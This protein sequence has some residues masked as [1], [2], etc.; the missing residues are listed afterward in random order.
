MMRAADTVMDS[1]V[2]PEHA[3]NITQ[4]IFE[5]SGRDHQIVHD[6]LL[7][8][9]GDDGDD[10]LHDVNHMYWTDDGKAAGSLFSWTNEAH[11]GPEADIASATAEK[12]AQY[13]GS[14]KDELMN[15]PGMP[16]EMTLGQVNPELVKGYAH[17]LTPYMADIASISGGNPDDN[18]GFLDPANSER[19]N[20]KG[21]FSVLGTQH[22]AYVE[23]NGAADQLGLERAHQY[24]E[25]VKH[26]VD[27]HKNDARILD[28]AVLKGLVASGSAESAHALALN[29]AEAQ[30][31]RKGAYS[32]LASLA[33][34]RWRGPLAGPG[35]RACF[36]SAMESSF[37]G[38]PH[39]IRR[40]RSVPDMTGDESARFVLNALLADG[41]P[42]EGIDPNYM[43]NGRIA[44]LAELQ[45]RAESV[46]SDTD[47]EGQLNT[48]L[49]NVVG[50][51][52]NPAD[53]FEDKYEQVTKIPGAK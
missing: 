10:F 38:S 33:W 22:D 37:I 47:F 27:V 44:S 36:G 1:D 12:Y 34:A 11:A 53:E 48:V 39:R 9:H 46:Q 19:P 24:A 32:T 13:I 41:V 49:D 14:H 50:E 29:Q 6:H 25:D 35:R 31:W 18:F 8:T 17:G 2:S 15:L 40:R 26:G 52:S 28:A 51:D 5:A 21:L 42:V 43:E 30:T 3:A 20:A 7:G 23:F 45:A 4:E 16:G